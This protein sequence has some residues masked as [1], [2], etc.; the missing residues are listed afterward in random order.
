MNRFL[1]YGISAI[2][3]LILYAHASKADDN[4]IISCLQ[5]QPNINYDEIDHT[6]QSNGH[7][8]R[9]I[10]FDPDKISL[11]ANLTPDGWVLSEGHRE[12]KGKTKQ[13]EKICTHGCKTVSDLSQYADERHALTACQSIITGLDY[14][15]STRAENES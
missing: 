2:A 4:K 9:F 12:S 14:E 10:R 6:L 3:I 5:Q 15:E 7:E 8:I 11:D 13:V 1:K